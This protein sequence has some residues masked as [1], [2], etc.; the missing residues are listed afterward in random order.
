MMS[1]SKIKR[2]LSV[3]CVLAMI[4][5]GVWFSNKLMMNK[6]SGEQYDQFFKAE[7][8][9]DVLFL[10]SSHMINGVSP[11]DLFREYGITCQCMAIMLPVVITSL[12]K[13]WRY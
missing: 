7:Q 12:R 1:K 5:G 9:F 10:G 13:A 2:L 8:D 3:L 4:G 6:A 11:L